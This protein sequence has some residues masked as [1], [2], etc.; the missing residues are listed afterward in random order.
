MDKRQ[1]QLIAEIAFLRNRI[2]QLEDDAA[3]AGTPVAQ[4][5]AQPR[6]NSE[7]EQPIVPPASFERRYY[8]LIQRS[9]DGYALLDMD[10][11]FV[12]CNP[13]YYTMLGYT[14]E[15]LRDRTYADITPERWQA[16]DEAGLERMLKT[17]YCDLYEKEYRRKDGT[18]FP[19][20]IQSYLIRDDDGNPSGMW[21]FVRDIA[22]R[23]RAEDELTRA[24]REWQSTF[25]AANDGIALIDK[26]AHLVRCNRAMGELFGVPVDQMVG[27]KCWEIVH[28]TSGP[29]DECPV[30][31][32]RETLQ[33]ESMVLTRG[34]NWLEIT[35]DPLL[36]PDGELAGA[37]HVV[38]DVTERIRAGNALRESEAKYRYLFEHMAQ[39]AFY[40]R[41]DGV[42]TDCNAALLDI[43]G[44]TRDE[45]LGRTSMNPEWRVIREDGTELPG[46]EHPSVRALR[47][48]KPVRG[49]VAG[50]FNP[51]RQDYAWVSINA[52]PEFR[53]GES[54]PYQASV[55]VHDITERKRIVQQLQESEARFRTMAQH[56]PMGMYMTDAAGQRTFVNEAWCMVSGMSATDAFGSG[57]V[58][59]LHPDDCD[60]VAVTWDTMVQS[61]GIWRQEYRFRHPSGTVR[62]VD[63]YAAPMLDQTGEVMGYVGMS[64]DVTERKQAEEELRAARER[65]FQ[66]ER[67][68]TIG[69]VSAGIAHEINNPLASVASSAELLTERLVGAARE[70]ASVDK[71]LGRIADGVERCKGII[72]SVRGFARKDIG[73]AVDIHVGD[74]IDSCLTALR[75]E[76]GVPNGRIRCAAGLFEFTDISTDFRHVRDGCACGSLRDCCIRAIPGQLDRI[77]ANLLRN[78]VEATDE[79]GVVLLG[80]DVSENGVTIAVGDTGTG[81]APSDLPL[82][83]EPF[84]TSKRG[85]GRGLG[86]HI[87]RQIVEFSGGRLTCESVENVGSLFRVW[88]PRARREEEDND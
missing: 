37:V 11:E 49:V 17:G 86:L 53:E 62:W 15:E 59:G 33:R 54:A 27:R 66:T 9:R 78:A 24:A 41:A 36:T 47:T 45:F 72:E 79:D 61:K 50:V 13:A 21:S 69:R 20:E 32:M 16:S 4:G 84:F 46:D 43:F 10:G 52:I 23:K 34:E 19:V 12:L 81:I 88:L 63:G 40:Q 42:L 70:D 35:V 38:S 29:I 22:E 5:N 87:S 73:E 56:A 44:L 2:A 82:I 1:D 76:S 8:E 75:D 28:G 48:G 67:S 65:L 39:G 18:L 55:T 80:C 25:D 6:L 3:D 77:L 30:V 26:D 64:V 71:H 51:K 57:W 74:I 85:G 58:A 68:A 7:H 14:K 31:R 60:R 83:F